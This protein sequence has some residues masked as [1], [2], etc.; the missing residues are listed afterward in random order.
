MTF[1]VCENTGDRESMNSG[2]KL[3][4][5]E[6]YYKS[7]PFKFGYDAQLHKCKDTGVGIRWLGLEFVPAAVILIIAK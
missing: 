3:E 5:L 7:S 1:L 4:N 2:K 6:K